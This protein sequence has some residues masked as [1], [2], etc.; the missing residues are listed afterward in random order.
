MTHNFRLPDTMLLLSRTPSTL[1]ALIRQLP[2]QWTHRDEG[3]RTWT[4]FDVIGHLIHG[5]RTDWIPRIALILKFGE[6]RTFDPFDR[7]AQAQES[8]G[9]TLMQLLDEFARLRSENLDALREMDL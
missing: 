8:Q 3:Q 6:D 7:F 4:V 9:K 2:E 1:D 5:E